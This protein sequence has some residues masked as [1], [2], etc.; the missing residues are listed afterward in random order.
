MSLGG[1][2]LPLEVRG[3][4]SGWQIDSDRVVR[5]VLSEVVLSK[6]FPYLIGGYAD[7]SVLPCVEILRK[8]EEFHTDR[9]F[10]ER[11]VRSANR[12]LDDVLEELLASLAGAKRGAIQQAIQ[13]SP[14][15]S[16]A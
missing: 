10:F 8:L 16:L 9:A 11:A 3:I 13:F 1:R 5:T 12:V 15:I 2:R 14:Y 4:R 7:D 6:S